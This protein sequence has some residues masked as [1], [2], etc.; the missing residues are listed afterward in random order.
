MVHLLHDHLISPE[1]V[2]AYHDKVKIIVE[3]LDFDRAALVGKLPAQMAFTDSIRKDFGLYLGLGLALSYLLLALV[4][5]SLVAAIL[6]YFVSVTALVW[7]LGAMALTGAPISFV[8]ALIPPIIL[9][10]SSSDSIHLLNAFKQ[11]PGSSRHTRMLKA[12]NAVFRPTL[13][14]SLTTV[15]GFMSLLTIDTLPI[16]QLGLYTS[17]GVMIA[18]FLTFAFGPLL[19]TKTSPSGRSF[20]FARRWTVFVFRQKHTI[21]IALILAMGACV[22]GIRQLHVDARLLDD[23]PI[24]SQVQKDFALA[25]SIFSGSKPF[26]MA[27]WTGEGTIWQYKVLWEINQIESAIRDVYVTS[28]VMSPASLVA[29]ANY[30]HHGGD[31]SHDVFPTSQAAWEE[32]KPTLTQLLRRPELPN[33]T[34]SN[35]GYARISAFMPEYGSRVDL[36]KNEQLLQRLKTSLGPGTLQYQITGTT[37]LI[38]RS[39]ASLSANLFQGLS[40]G[41]FIIGAFLGIYFR[42]WKLLLISLVPN[43]I[44]LMGLAG[45]M[46][47]MDLPLK[48]TTAITFTVA[49]GIAVD[50]TIHL[51]ASYMASPLRQPLHRI[52]AVYRSTGQAV[53]IT[54]I[55][56]I[57]G[58]ALF[59]TSSFGATYFLGLFLCLSLSLALVTDLL[60]LPL[61]LYYCKEHF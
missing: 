5:R 20:D 13:L 54:T 32:L 9:F 60:I 16:R 7:L 4:L 51:V 46:A 8:G 55:V 44:P 18:F 52:T 35:M 25:D 59:L 26:E 17:L 2:L 43:M 10:V 27:V 34:G 15:V 42:S 22:V 41:I 30:I 36:L 24:D 3:E 21:L 40:L 37:Y 56:I 45:L 58:F 28:R 53:I 57:F 14:T 19:I 1:E 48:L 31:Q 29:Y 6:P 12:Y 11:A 47:V 61:L 33:T 49:F 23:L 50:D 39:H 38:D